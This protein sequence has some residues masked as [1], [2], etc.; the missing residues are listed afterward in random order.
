MITLLGTAYPIIQAP[1]AGISTPALAAAVSNAGAL[2]SLGVGASSVDQ[3][4]STITQTQSLTDKPI[5][6]NVFCN[7]PPRRNRNIEA[8]W[9]GHFSAFFDKF[10]AKP[11]ESLSEIYQTFVV[12]ED[13]FRMLL[14]VRPAF[15]SFHLAFHQLKR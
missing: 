9:I 10:C 13:A 5:N 11:P 6:V 12:A 14:E 3:A 15:V 7:A 4:R 2:G 1:M 8:A